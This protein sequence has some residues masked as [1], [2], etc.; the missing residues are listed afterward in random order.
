MN[1]STIHVFEPGE[2]ARE[3]RERLLCALEAFVNLGNSL[4]DYL[5]F[6]K[7][8]T[9]FFPF[10]IL[11]KAQRSETPLTPPAVQGTSLTVEGEKKIWTKIIAWEPACH[12]LVLFY[13]DIL[14]VACWPTIPSRN[15]TFAGDTFLLLLGID[16]PA[17]N[18]NW[19][20][21][22]KEIQ[23]IYPAANAVAPEFSR[24]QADWKTGTFEYKPD[25]DFQ[26]AI[27]ILFREGWR[28]KTCLRCSRRFVASKAVQSYCST[29]CSGEAKRKRNLDWWNRSGKKLR[30]K[31]QKLPSGKHTISRQKGGK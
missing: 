31:A 22:F 1:R 20:E 4:E 21:A 10:E 15:D 24:L 3:E 23:A 17:G 7:Q 14:Q 16:P 6:G 19:V 13:R 2:L 26:R 18:G 9:E 11:D 12:K 30:K 29:K 25:N 8:N 28:A 5:A 27:Y